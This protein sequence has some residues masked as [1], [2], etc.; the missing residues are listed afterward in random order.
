MN[1][2][3]LDK[4]RAEYLVDEVIIPSLKLDIREP[5][6]NFLQV[7]EDDDNPVVIAIVKSLKSYLAGSI[8]PQ[9]KGSL[10]HQPYSFPVGPDSPRQPYRYIDPSPGQPYPGQPYPGQTYS[11]QSYP[12]PPSPGYQH[13]P[14]YFEQSYPGSTPGQPYPGSNPGQP[15]PG[16][17]Y[18]GQPNPGHQPSY[19]QQPYP[20]GQ[21]YPG[22]PYT[23][24]PYPG[25]AYTGQPYPGQGYNGQA[26]SGHP[27]PQG[28]DY[29][30]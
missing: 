5:F 28:Y 18:N 16:Q 14:S 10:P 4:D 21:L 8:P 9:R 24:Q 6:D 30:N 19:S 2:M 3:T 1:A 23:G 17:A 25:Q 20:G 26:Y 27:Y 13:Q 12:V 7:L 15:Y 29:M 11:G 22:Q